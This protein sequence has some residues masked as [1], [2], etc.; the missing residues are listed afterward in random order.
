MQP[1]SPYLSLLLALLLPAGSL[2]LAAAPARAKHPR[3]L[4]LPQTLARILSDPAVNQAHWGISVASSSGKPI[5]ALNDG[6]YFNPA[7]NAKL[8]TTAAAYALLPTG[9]T[10]TTVVASAAPVNSSGELDGNVTIFG[11]GDPNL[12]ARTVPFGL[13]TERPGPPLA[14]LEDMADQIVR[15]GVHTIAGDIV[16]DD[17]WF[18]YERYASG[19]SWDDLQWGYGAPVSALSVNDNEV[20]LN[21]MPAAQVGDIAMASWLPR[22]AYY[23]LDNSLSTSAPGD[24]IQPGVERWPG[25]MT[26]RLFGRTPRGQQGFHTSLAIEDPADYAARSLKEMLVA[27]GV[28]VSG[29]ARAEHRLPSDTGDFFQEQEQP[30]TL[31]PVTLL[32]LQAV[33]PGQTLLASHVSPPL[34]DDLVITN[35]VSQ[36]LHAEMT[37]RTLGKLEST[38]GS[39]VEG[40]RVVRQF[41][42]SAGIN[43]ADFV[44]FDG[45]GLSMQDLVAPRAFTTLLVYAARQSWGEAFRT[46]LP[47]GGVDGSLSGRFKQ[48]LLDGKLYAKT[49]TL[50]EARA[51]SGYLVAAS[52]QTVVFSIMCTDHRPSVPA[53]RV[54]MDKIVAA[55]AESN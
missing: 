14:I 24:P 48:P 39:L 18:L 47:V 20:Y 5:Y 10:F 45:C 25:S 27:R 21:A 46:S 12:S 38:D 31:H 3:R 9:L 23:T 22:T 29:T 37:L 43:P 55:I 19:W 52:G 26:V 17:T 36:N 16:G 49:G 42:I 1:R 11:V 34:G 13:K 2:S 35:K 41:L 44:L 15:R 28:R 40:T 7:S 53:D 51:L 4:P 33:N 54:A 32:N 30:V 8:F 6:Q 50:G